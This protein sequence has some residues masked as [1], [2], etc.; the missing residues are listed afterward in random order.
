MNITTVLG[1]AQIWSTIFAPS[2]T[3][4]SLVPAMVFVGA[5]NQTLAASTTVDIQPAASG[6]NLSVVALAGAAGTFTVN[7]FDG[8]RVYG[9]LSIAAGQTNGI[10]AIVTQPGLC[11]IRLANN[12]AVNSARY[13][14]NG[15]QLT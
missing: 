1:P 13:A 5:Q 7:I 15:Y 11:S 6:L 3:I 14:F 9:L 2:R 10:P 8:T 12:D 4:T